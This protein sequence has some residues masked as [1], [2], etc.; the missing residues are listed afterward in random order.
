M[1]YWLNP[2]GIQ[3]THSLFYEEYNQES[4][5]AKSVAPEG[6]IIHNLDL[7]GSIYKRTMVVVKCPNTIEGLGDKVNAPLCGVVYKAEDNYIVT[8]SETYPYPK[9]N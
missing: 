6:S 5:Q 9:N 4:T 8:W 3:S 7:E 1:E 2:R